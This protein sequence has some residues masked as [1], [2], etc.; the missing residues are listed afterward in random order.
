MKKYYEEKRIRPDVLTP[1]LFRNAGPACLRGK[2][3]EG[4][5]SCGQAM[6]IRQER[7]NMIKT[8]EKE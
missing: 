1:A 3:P 8:Y 2:C 6:I 4:E 7:E 5:K